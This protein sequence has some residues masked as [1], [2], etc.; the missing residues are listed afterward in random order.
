MWWNGVCGGAGYVV[1]RGMWRNGVCGGTGYVVERGMWGNGI[2]G[3][4]GYI[5]V[6]IVIE[7]T[8]MQGRGQTDLGV[9]VEQGI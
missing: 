5:V 7:G 8:C 1:E 2:C 9:L 6:Y 3:G 4:M